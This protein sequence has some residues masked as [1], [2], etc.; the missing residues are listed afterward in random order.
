MEGNMRIICLKGICECTFLFEGPITIEIIPF[1]PF[2]LFQ[3]FHPK[4]SPVRKGE[5]RREEEEQRSK[6]RQRTKRYYPF[7]S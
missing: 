1:F 3:D 7:K 6:I 5:N 4:Y 2:F